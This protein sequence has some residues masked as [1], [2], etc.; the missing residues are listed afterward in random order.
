MI[1]GFT[2]VDVVFVLIILILVIRGGMR[3]FI[4]EVST[5][6]APLL[7]LLCAVIFSNLV[8]ELVGLLTGMTNSIWNYI[9]AFLGVFLVVYLIIFFIQ[10]TL[11]SIVTKLELH[12]LD[13]VLGSILGL[14]EGILIIAII[15]ILAYW[16]PIEGLK[17]SFESS[18][19]FNLLKPFIPSIPDIFKLVPLRE[20]CLKI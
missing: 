19:F 3:G 5:L 20:A 1:S 18:F 9:I 11:Q 16:I 10:G 2:I 15:L 6:A 14:V 12:N 17:Q 8:T 7:G 13:R 4:I